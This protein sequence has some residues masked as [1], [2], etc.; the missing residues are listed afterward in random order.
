MIQSISSNVHASMNASDLQTPLKS[1]SWLETE[2]RSIVVLEHSCFLFFPSLFS[3]KGI[4]PVMPTD[5]KISL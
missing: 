4:F 2:A 1:K 3:N 5:K